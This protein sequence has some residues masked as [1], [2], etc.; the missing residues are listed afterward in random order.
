MQT[1]ADPPAARARA[2]KRPHPR[3]GAY[4]VDGVNDELCAFV[5][6]VDRGVGVVRRF[7]VADVARVQWF[8]PAVG[9]DLCGPTVSAPNMAEQLPQR[10]VGAGRHGR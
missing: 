2:E 1:T 7:A 9:D 6:P 8:G 5:Q 10:P 4:A 3:V